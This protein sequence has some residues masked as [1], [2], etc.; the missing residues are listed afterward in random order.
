MLSYD[1]GSLASVCTYIFF[2]FQIGTLIWIVSSLFYFNVNAK[3]LDWFLALIWKVFCFANTNNLLKRRKINT[4]CSKAVYIQI[5]CRAHNNKTKNW[6]SNDV[7][8]HVKWR[9]SESF[10]CSVKLLLESS[11]RNTTEL[12]LSLIFTYPYES[13]LCNSTYYAV[14]LAQVR[15]GDVEYYLRNV[16]Y[17]YIDIVFQVRLLFAV[18]IKHFYFFRFAHSLYR[19]DISVTLFDTRL[20]RT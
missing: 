13:H 4:S 3:S 1:K 17:I 15:L 9:N 16:F 19:F 6:V 20:N 18:L 8:Y 12:P 11:L 14:S 5:I 2:P 7:N 10:L